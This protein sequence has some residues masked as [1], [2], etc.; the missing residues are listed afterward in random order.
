MWT[1]YLIAIV[2]CIIGFIIK[3]FD[4]K[5]SYKEWISG[6][7]LAFIIAGVMHLCTIKGMLEDQE[8][9]SGQIINA[10]YYPEWV[11]EYQ[12]A[13]YRTE[14]RPTMHIDSDGDLRTGIESYQVFDHYEPRHRTHNA[15]AEAFGSYGADGQTYPISVSSFEDFARQFGDRT[16]SRAT[17]KGFDGGDP[18][19]YTTKNLTKAVIPIVTTKSFENKIKA[20]PSTFSYD[21]VPK[22]IPVFDYPANNNVWVS[23]RLLGDAK[24]KISIEE[25]D[26]MNARLGPVK[27]VNVI[28]IGFN[29]ADS[30]L[31]HYQEEKFIGGKKNDIVICYGMGALEGDEVQ[32]VW[33]RCF[34]WCENDQ[35]KRNIEKIFME[36]P[37]NNDILPL[38]EEQI[39]KDYVKKEWSKFDYIKVKPTAGWYWTLCIIMFA[40]QIALY[41]FFHMNDPDAQNY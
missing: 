25:L 4:D 10:T 21:K 2:P 36:H 16:T 13:I 12:V 23:D 40:I 39:R 37:V 1:Y 18:N 15:Y 7:I 31:G 34:G 19:I 28:I 8:T 29:S 22:D 14:Y 6:S 5:V 41:L 35:L 9:W 11:E 27:K 17:K 30:K 20:S 38:I 32:M 26:K 24:N 3:R 33:T